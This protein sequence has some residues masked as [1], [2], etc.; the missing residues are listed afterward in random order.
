MPHLPLD[1]HCYRF[2]LKAFISFSTELYGKSS[3]S[4]IWVVVAIVIVD[5]VYV[6]VVI[7]DVFAV[8]LSVAKKLRA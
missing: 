3:S 4:S 7:I 8:E 5:V 1:P 2:F 6:I